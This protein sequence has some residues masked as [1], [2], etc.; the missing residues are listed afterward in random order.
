MWCIYIC[1]YKY[2]CMIAHTSLCVFS[3]G[4]FLKK[5][6][7]AV[8]LQV[9]SDLPFLTG[10]RTVTVL[11]RQTSDYEVTIYPSHHGHFMG[12]LSFTAG[13]VSYR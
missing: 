11:P 13:E 6:T 2:V 1:V 8:W 3:F 7:V 5:Q 9:E 12:I 4:N 10:P